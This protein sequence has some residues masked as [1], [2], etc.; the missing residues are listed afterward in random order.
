[1]NISN[2]KVRERFFLNDFYRLAHSSKSFV[3]NYLRI[4][5]RLLSKWVRRTSNDLP[6]HPET[7]SHSPFRVLF[8][9]SSLSWVAWIMHANNRKEENVLI[10]STQS[11][12]EREREAESRWVLS[13]SF[14]FSH[15]RTFWIPFKSFSGQRHSLSGA[16]G[17][18]IAL[19]IE[20][21]LVWGWCWGL[22]YHLINI[23]TVFLGPPPSLLLQCYLAVSS[24]S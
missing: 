14:P 22:R 23:H 7:H 10:T 4:N 15:S 24:Y 2:K 1:M 5:F 13:L 16:K 11:E 21:W 19:K 6:T 3:R 9:L 20:I 8:P 12:W 18:E 17:V